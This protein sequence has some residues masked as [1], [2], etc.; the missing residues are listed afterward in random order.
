MGQDTIKPK[1]KI[2]FSL[3]IMLLCIRLYSLGSIENDSTKLE[4]WM[5]VWAGEL[6][7]YTA[8]GLRQSVPMKVKHFKTD[9]LGTY[10][11][12]LIYGD[13][14]TGTRKYYL[15]TIDENKGHYL[16]D[17]KNSIFLNS[18]LIGNKMI[19]TFEVMNSLITSIYTLMQDGSMLFEIIYGSTAEVNK[20]GNTEIA[21]EK[22]PEVLS[23]TTQ[24]YQKALLTKIE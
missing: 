18:Y 22:I 11:W 21:D 24:G 17:E 19:S 23:Y 7:I 3:I 4:T 9:T 8:E 10:G 1:F 6:E 16:V 15:K 20:T 2:I 5:G 12:Y 14:E 13:E